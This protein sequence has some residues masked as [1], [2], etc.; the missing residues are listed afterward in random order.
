MDSKKNVKKDP[1]S[2][3]FVKKTEDIK[4][5]VTDNKPGNKG[6]NIGRSKLQT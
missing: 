3:P 1:K 6:G 4:K 2:G 5:S